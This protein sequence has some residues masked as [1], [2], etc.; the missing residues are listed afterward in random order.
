MNVLAV[1]SHVCYGHVGG[2]AA[3]LPL[4]RL[5]HEVW[6]V[7][8]VLFSNHPGHGSFQG[9]AVAP[10]LVQALLRGL[11]EG[12]FLARADA[13]LTGYLG[14]PEAAV[15]AAQALAEVRMHRSEAP[16]LVDPVLGDGGRMYV[17]DGILEAVRDR[18]LPLAGIVTPNRWELGWLTGRAVERP[19][20]VVAAARALCRHGPPLVLVTSAMESGREVSSLLVSR[21]GCWRIDAPRHARAPNGTGDLLA[22]LFLGRYLR[23]RKPELAFRHACSAVA[24]VLAAGAAEGLDELPLVARQDAL[25]RPIQALPMQRLD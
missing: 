15:A 16:V 5:G 7:P 18:L 11:A 21:A 19:E 8:T 13:A 1:T 10:A 25:V 4:Q 6:H 14:T 24:E 23:D 22:A 12:G 3:L 9:E 2:Q 17:R 20:D